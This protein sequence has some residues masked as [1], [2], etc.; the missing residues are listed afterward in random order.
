MVH[1]FLSEMDDA[2]LLGAKVGVPG[3]AD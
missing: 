2:R 3:A 1:A